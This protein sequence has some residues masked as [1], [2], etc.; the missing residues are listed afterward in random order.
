MDKPVKSVEDIL[1]MMPG[2]IPRPKLL[3]PGDYITLVQGPPK[4]DVN[5]NTGNRF[6]EY[7]LSIQQVG[8]NVIKYLEAHGGSVDEIIGRTIRAT[9]YI[10]EN[11]VSRLDDFL[12]HCGVIKGRLAERIPMAVNCQVGIVL[13]HRPNRE[14]TGFFPN[15]VRSF[16]PK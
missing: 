6:V 7:T 12:I 10:T 3:P 4:E 8:D 5:Q 13:N 9:F 16:A 11:A 1:N 2:E 15:V 14:Q